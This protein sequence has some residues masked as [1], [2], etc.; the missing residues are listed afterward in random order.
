MVDLPDP[1]LIA[2][3]NDGLAIRLSSSRG[4]ERFINITPEE[5]AEH[6]AAFAPLRSKYGK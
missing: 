6:N 3:E 5:A 4:D 2:A 1:M